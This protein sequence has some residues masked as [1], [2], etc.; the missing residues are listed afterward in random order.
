[1]D[2]VKGQNKIGAMDIRRILE[3]LPHRYPLLLVDRVLEM[4]GE[5]SIVCLKNVSA[6]EP[7][8]QGHFP[9][10][11][12]M[13]GVLIIEGLAQTAAVLG[14]SAIGQSDEPQMIYFMGIERAKFRRPVVPGDTLHFH[15][16][17]VRS[18]GRVWRFR[19]E[20]RVEGQ[21]VTEADISAMIIDQADIDD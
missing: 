2:D 6:N 14:I 21:I 8:F 7:Y 19:G 18:R 5:K 12:V 13:P 3:L 9:G 16:E 15:V 4:N 11:P 10:Y 20:A 17:K 1:M